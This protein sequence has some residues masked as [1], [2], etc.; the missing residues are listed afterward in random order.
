MLEGL[1]DDLLVRVLSWLDDDDGSGKAFESTLTALHRV[2]R[3]WNRALGADKTG[4]W[5]AMVTGIHPR[6]NRVRGNPDRR[7]ARRTTRSASEKA[8][9]PKQHFFRRRREIRHRLHREADA[10]IA[11][12]LVPRLQRADCALLVRKHLRASPRWWAR[13]QVPELEHRTL[14]H[15]A[16]WH[17]RTNTARVLLDHG[18][19]PRALDD[20]NASPLLIAAWAGRVCTTELLLDRLAPGDVRAHLAVRGVPPLTSSCGGKGPKPAREWARRKGFHRIARLL[21]KAA[22]AENPGESLR[23]TPVPVAAGGRAGD[24]PKGIPPTPDG[25]SD[26]LDGKDKMKGEKL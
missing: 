10:L 7:A 20:S 16:G 23:A 15:Y 26:R 6:S 2:C 12:V 3:S 5:N 4:F 1:S 24:T 22:A 9:D 18:A 21:E 11:R 14:L 17:G 19:S 8:T 13:H 25:T